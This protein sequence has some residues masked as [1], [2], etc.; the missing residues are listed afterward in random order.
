MTGNYEYDAIGEL[1]RQ[2]FENHQMPVDDN[3][4]DEIERRLGH[5]KNKSI[6][7]LWIG[8]SAAAAAV[9]L[10]VIINTVTYEPAVMIA[11]E[12][13]VPA[14]QNETIPII[15]A[16]ETTDDSIFNDSKIP[17]FNDSMIAFDEFVGIPFINDS[18]TQ[19]LSY[20][21]IPSFNDSVTQ[22]LS[23]SATP[24]LNDSVTQS[25]SHSVTQSLSYSITVD[26]IFE[27]DDLPA[28]KTDKWLLAAAFGMGG[29]ADNSS[30]ILVYD[31]Y[32]APSDYLGLSGSNNEYAT[33]LSNSIQPFRFMDREDFTNLTHLPPLSFGITARKNLGKYGGV[34]SGLVYTYLSSRFEWSGYDVHQYL[35]YL[36]IP[37]NMVVYLGNSKSNWR[38]YLSGGF[39]VEKGL[40][41]IYRQERQIQSEH[42]ITTVRS[43]IPGLQWSLNGG[44]GINYKLEKGWGIYFEPRFGFSFDCN[45]PVSIRTEYPIYFGVNLGLNYEF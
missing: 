41:A 1:F 33:D 28:K 6:K 36:G 14:V 27:E 15:T 26:D 4:W 16:Q 38:V 29:Y 30:N 3:D 9:A 40:R 10:L 35:H 42:R 32:Q 18:V 23:Y 17:L 13:S 5:K 37:V 31:T 43:H 44:L 24:S 34:E 12:K 45:Q 19:L 39:M 20:S 11:T 2:R 25:L 21:V 7:W 8:G 22:L